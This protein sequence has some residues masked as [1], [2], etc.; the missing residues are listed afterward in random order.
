MF[1][2]NIVVF[3]CYQPITA[4]PIEMVTASVASHLVVMLDDMYRRKII[5]PIYNEECSTYYP[6]TTPHGQSQVDFSAVSL[7]IPAIQITF[8]LTVACVSSILSALLSTIISCNAVRTVLLTTVVGSICIARPIKMAY[9]RGLDIMFDALRP[10]MLVYILSLVCEQLLHSCRP[11]DDENSSS[12]FR[13]WLFHAGVVCMMF[14]G[15]WQSSRPHDQTDHPFVVTFTTLVI[16]TMFAPPPDRG[17]GPLCDIPEMYD[18]IERVVRV[19]IFSWVYNTI[20]YACEPSKHSIGEI[21]L[22]AVRATSASIWTL[23][24][25]RWLLI[26]GI[27]QGILVVSAR[28]RKQKIIYDGVSDDEYDD[29]ESLS[30]QNSRNLPYSQ[31]APHSPYFPE[32]AHLLNS[33]IASDEIETGIQE[34]PVI[35]IGMLSANANKSHHILNSSRSFI[36]NASINPPNNQY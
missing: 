18:S 22:C 31:L 29:R 26:V 17:M 2:Y 4:I 20:A 8:A 35:D 1:D 12:A 30:S 7:Y 21:M 10:S 24:C 15:I 25:I 32:K 14:S 19:L 28:V 23:C 9:A 33:H 3:F 5:D 36:P 6:M 16:I 11:I 27:L 13:T 34:S